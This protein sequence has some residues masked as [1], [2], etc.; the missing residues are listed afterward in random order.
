MKK[1]LV[2]GGCGFIG[3]EFVRQGLERNYEIIVLDKLT[4]AGDLRRIPKG[5][6][7]FYKG[8]I[9]D[10]DT[11]RRILRRERPDYLVNFAAETHV[12]RSIFDPSLF[13]ETNVKG[14]HTLLEA[15]RTYGVEKFLQ[16]STDEVYGEIKKGKFTEESPFLP[17][18]PYAVS[19]AASDMLVK[20]YYRTY[21]LPILIVRPSNTYGPYQYPEKLIPLVIYSALKNKKIPVYGKG[22]NV[23]EWFY[24]ADCAE[25]I[26]QVLEKGR[27]GEAYNIASGEEKKN[28]DVVKSILSLLEKPLSLI[29]FVRDRP[30]HDFRYALS[31]KKVRR[32]LGW[33]AKTR[34]AEGL[35]KTVDW[36]LENFSW[37][38]EKIKEERAYFRRFSKFYLSE[39]RLRR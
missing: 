35:R 9:A 21:N 31:T 27:I 17:N 20:A 30:G 6:V 19:K 26:F 1:I 2:T 11:V 13:L 37:V 32:E 25:G 22:E 33:R 28:I 4:Y 15:I 34:F 18:S 8:D 14:T 10:R 12:D 3:S 24:V 36:Y 16:V 5:E 29:Q 7:K 39:R 38:E 23:R